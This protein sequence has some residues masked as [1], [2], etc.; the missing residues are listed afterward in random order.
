METP[1]AMPAGYLA[2]E[3][4]IGRVSADADP[5]AATALLM[6]ACFQQAFLHY[7]RGDSDFAESAADD[8]VQALLP[9]LRR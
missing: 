5:A 4:T 9:A 3:Q 2:A 8:L 7:F 1:V 6:G